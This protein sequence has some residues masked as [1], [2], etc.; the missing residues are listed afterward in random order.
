MKK[1]MLSG[2]TKKFLLPLTLIA[3]ISGIASAQDGAV[4]ETAETAVTKKDGPVLGGTFQML[5]AVEYLEVKDNSPTDRQDTRMYLFLK[6]ARL[7][8]SGSVDDI[9]YYFQLQFGGE[10]VPNG[11]NSVYSLLDAYIDAP[12]AGDNLGIRVGQFKVPFSREMLTDPAS[13]QFVDTS[14]NTS[15]FNIQRD[16]G[17]AFHGQFSD[18]HWA[19]GTFTGGGI[20]IPQRY[21]PQGLGMP[22]MVARVGY[23]TLDRDIFKP[24][25]SDVQRKGTGFAAYVSGSY[26]KNSSVGHGSVFATKKT[27]VSW[28]KNPAWNTNFSRMDTTSP[29]P[30]DS[31][32]DQTLTQFEADIAYQTEVAG[33]KLFMSAEGNYGKFSSPT[34]NLALKGGAAHFAAGYDIAEV[35]LRYA[36]IIPD[37]RAGYYHT[38]STMF[39]PIF[40]DNSPV[41]QI[42]PALNFYVNEALTIKMDLDVW[43]NTPV[44][45]EAASGAYNLMIQ[46]QTSYA[47]KTAPDVSTVGRE[48]A[49]TARMVAQMVF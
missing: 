41:H 36:M 21:L 37:E 16:V 5:G 23:D 1:S 29:V 17:F 43:I 49:V 9:D 22:Q 15:V 4:N 32:N 47:Q 3:G 10:E 28:F 20:D 2:L 45:Q 19:L 7:N 11:S 30:V 44:V 48:N 35:A 24:G 13:L 18:L 39:Y 14:I 6:Q 38:A 46:P 42:N 26:E 25:Q 40:K 8:V 12:L 31:Y 34:G 27:D 33:F